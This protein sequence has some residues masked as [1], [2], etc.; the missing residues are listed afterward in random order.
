MRALRWAVLRFVVGS[1]A[2]PLFSN[3]FALGRVRSLPFLFEK[4]KQ[5]LGKLRVESDPPSVSRERRPISAFSA[6]ENPV[7]PVHPDGRFAQRRRF[8]L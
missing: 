4:E 3:V 6:Q 7:N 1:A 5:K 8:G 2:N